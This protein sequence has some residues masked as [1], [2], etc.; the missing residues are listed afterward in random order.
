MGST[1]SFDLSG[2]FRNIFKQKNTLKL[3]DLGIARIVE[4]S[5]SLRD[6]KIAGTFS[7]MSPELLHDEKYSVKSDIW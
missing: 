5:K 7:Y 2:I 6:T 1:T 4:S 3:G